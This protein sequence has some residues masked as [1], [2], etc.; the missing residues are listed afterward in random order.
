MLS[1]GLV[2]LLSANTPER[3]KAVLKSVK[4]KNKMSE[5]RRTYKQKHE[6]HGKL[7]SLANCWLEWAC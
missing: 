3:K 7:A 5:S 1:T 4:Y 6:T 2:G